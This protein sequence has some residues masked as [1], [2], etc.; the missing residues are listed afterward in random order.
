MAWW[1]RTS[2][3]WFIDSCKSNTCVWQ[4]SVVNCD[5]GC[6]VV[7]FSH[8]SNF[9]C[10][11]SE[12]LFPYHF[13]EYLQWI[14]LKYK[15]ENILHYF[16]ILAVLSEITQLKYS[17]NF[18]AAVYGFVWPLTGLSD[19]CLER[20]KGTSVSV[21]GFRSWEASSLRRIN[22]FHVVIEHIIAFCVVAYISYSK[23][24]YNVM[25]L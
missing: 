19:T 9:S 6:N 12:W 1:Y 10:C 13:V 23:Y 18:W 7:Q 14:T 11:Y 24:W 21:S 8:P 16:T 22:P 20:F 4:F 17:L 5:S 3:R 25:Y 15:S 2:A